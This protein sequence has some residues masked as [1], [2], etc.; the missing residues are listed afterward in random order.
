MDTI[1]AMRVF[2]AVV[3]RS[4]F[5]G[6]AEAMEMSTASVTRH[7]AWLEQRLGTR[8][9]H[10]TTRRVSLT[11]AGASYHERCLALLAELDA[12]EAAVTAQSLAPSGQLRINVPVS[13]GIAH[14]G[15]MLGRFADLHPQISVDVDLSD[16]L[17][18]LVEEG[19]DVAIRITREPAPSLIARLLAESALVVCAAPDYLARAGT[20]AT[21]AD[22][23][24][25]RCLGY[26]YWHGGDVWRMSG[27]AGEESVRVVE[28]LRA[29]NGDLLREAAIAGMGIVLQPEFIVGQALE[30]GRLLPLLPDYRIAPV[31]IYAVYASRSHLAPKVRAF[32]DFMVEAFADTCGT[33]VTA[34]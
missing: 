28:H 13:F 16:R 17:V 4:S 29:N 14:M 12:T 10:R 5:S 3:E 18:D 20:P 32:I 25:H 9:L 22:L 1:E 15:A 23:A 11:S 30:D 19:Y 6:A 21:L 26:R 8:L 7:V 24:A 2:A 27:P 33:R 31:R 34:A